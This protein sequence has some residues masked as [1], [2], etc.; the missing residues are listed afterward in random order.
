ML[1][2]RVA[3]RLIQSLLQDLPEHGPD[4]EEFGSQAF[5]ELL[6][7]R[8]IPVKLADPGLDLIGALRFT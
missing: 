1:E 6:D 4:L 3:F 7:A 8:K 5:A 2:G